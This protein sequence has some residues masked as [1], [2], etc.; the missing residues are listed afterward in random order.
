MK[1]VPCGDSGF[2]KKTTYCAYDATCY[3]LVKD[4]ALWRRTTDSR[5]GTFCSKVVSACPC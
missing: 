2:Y 4:N 5:D 1:Y 3:R